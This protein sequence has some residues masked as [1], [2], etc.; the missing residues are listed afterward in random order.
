MTDMKRTESSTL[1]LNERAGSDTQTLNPASI[2]MLCGL[3][4]L[5]PACGGGGFSPTEVV[6]STVSGVSLGNSSP[7]SSVANVNTPTNDTFVRIQFTVAGNSGVMITIT[8]KY[9]IDADAS[10]TMNG[11][12]VS[13]AMT[14]APMS[15]VDSINVFPSTAGSQTIPLSGSFEGV[16]YWDAMTDLGGL[17]AKYGVVICV[18][19]NGSNQMVVPAE[20]AM[21]GQTFASSSSA[22]S[23]T[24]S[25]TAPSAAGTGRSNHTSNSVSGLNGMASPM[26]MGAEV[27]V[28]GGLDSTTAALNSLDRFS[29]DVAGGTA[30]NSASNA[31]ANARVGHASAMFLDTTTG[32]N[33]R[34]LVTGGSPAG[35]ATNTADIYSF[36]PN[37]AESVT[38]TGAPMTIE[39]QGHASCWLPNN[40]ILI[41]GGL[42]SMGNVVSSAEIFDPAN[43]G[44]PFTA[45]MSVPAD[46]GRIG[47]TQTLLPDGTVLIA[48]GAA[49]LTN[50][51]NVYIFNPANNSFSVAPVAGSPAPGGAGTAG[52]AT[53]RKNH[54]A[55]L[56]VNG[57]VALSGGTNASGSMALDSVDFYRPF[58]VTDAATGAIIPS[59]FTTP[60]KRNGPDEIS[61]AVPVNSIVARER[62]SASRLGDGR[63]LFVSGEN[64]GGGI[65]SSE[66]F[67]PFAMN[68]NAIGAF[69]LTNPAGDPAFDL[70]AA[71]TSHTQ[72]TLQDGSVAVIGGQSL[73]TPLDTIEVFRFSNSRP[74]A[75]NVTVSGAAGGDLTI[76]FD[77]AD[78]END[79]SFVIVRYSINSGPFMFATLN[80]Y[81]NTVNLD[82]GAKTLTW[83][84]VNDMVMIGDSVVVEVVPVGG[85]FGDPGRSAATAI[86]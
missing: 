18:A 19:V 29:I 25:I 27:L 56:M 44:S 57:I 70:A 38:P 74:T 79:R 32:K 63:L 58:A 82:T 11:S 53:D 2:L 69:T 64:P 78:A 14:E 21:N 77:L 86:N 61:P 24:G 7:G 23:L 6:P 28:A 67:V 12:E 51:V 37:G 4:A 42:D 39:R 76:N 60:N 46:L 1:R 40:T 55:T 84:A 5:I 48:G 17:G 50:Q 13:L 8:P 22:N 43:A 31:G 81:A 16:F 9:Y 49:G 47:H 72:T 36:G 34:I 54:T 20:L 52:T 85:S 83:E 30:A 68:D 33:V 73:G 62:H 65:V 41:T 3:L 75:S 59:G 66:F 80:D 45:I 15:S 10:N 26:D 35:T 71:R